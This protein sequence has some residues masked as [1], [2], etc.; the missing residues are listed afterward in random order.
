M[1]FGCGTGSTA[2]AHAPH[3]GHVLASDIS[4]RMLG[5][6]RRKAA[7]AGVGNVTFRA[8]SI[9]T[10][11]VAPGSADAVLGLSILH[12]LRDRD[13]AIARVRAMLRPGG[14]FVSSTACIGDGMGWFRLVAPLGRAL[15]LL[16]YVAVFR[17]RDLR[18]D[19]T[20][21]GFVIEHDWQPNDGRTLF[22]VARKPG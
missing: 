10:L 15:G 12:L 17:A 18:R 22:L 1:E 19:L 8:A 14:V 5:I 9:E 2:L 4:P 21:H 6:A 13:A 3:V 11:E 7:E 16:P 20:R